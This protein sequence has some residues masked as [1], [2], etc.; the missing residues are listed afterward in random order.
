MG[1]NTWSFKVVWMSV[2]RG[3]KRRPKNRGARYR[4]AGKRAGAASTV[5]AER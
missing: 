3:V 4:E 2:R 5:T 1:A